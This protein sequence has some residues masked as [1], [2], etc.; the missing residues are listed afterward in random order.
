MPDTMSGIGSLSQSETPTA[1][2]DAQV[3]VLEV[4]QE[5]ERQQDVRDIPG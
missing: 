2:T 3:D 4:V 1:A 5:K